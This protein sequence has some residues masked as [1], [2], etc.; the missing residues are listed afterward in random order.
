MPNIS[1]YAESVGTFID[2]WD[3]Q[4]VEPFKNL[5]PLTADAKFSAAD[6]VGGVYHVATRL[7]Y[8]GG[9]TFAAPQTQPGQLSTP[10][11]GPRAGITPDAQIQGMQVHGRSQV[12]YE[13]LARSAQN[14]NSTE[15]DRKKA[16]R[17]ASKIVM[18][19][20]LQGVLKKIE[21]QMLHGR[22]GLG[23]GDTT[24]AT[25]S[26]VVATTYESV[27]G[28][29]VDVALS[30]ATWSEA[31]WLMSEGHTFDIYANTSG[32]PAGAKLNTNPNTALAG[33]NQ[34]GLILTA[35]NP[36]TPLANGVATGRVIRLFSSDGAAGAA[37]TGDVGGWVQPIPANNTQHVMFESATPTVEFVGLGLMA[38][39][40]GTL[41]NINAATYSMYRGNLLPNVGNVRLSTLIRAFARPINAGGAGLKYR[42]VVPTELFAQFA[43]DEST[44]RR[45]ASV[46]GKAENGFDTIEMYLPQG[47]VL[48]VLGHNLQK[49]GIITGYVPD[50]VKRIGSQ[51]L[52]FVNRS[53]RR[54]E[55]F[56]LEV[57]NSPASELRLFGQFAPICETPRHMLKMTG[58]TF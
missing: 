12:T 46:T 34:N 24:V 21:T 27:A 58:V 54:K 50:E 17:A 28:F 1:G 14:V 47:S 31:I 36:A 6:M 49:D 41:F 45:Y 8:E 51:D 32:L 42:A 39:N 25:C 2:A 15:T 22:E 56:V 18:E 4:L 26:D 44:L 53:A 23:Q 35:I 33:T 52:D 9:V 37:G 3:N 55:D 29:H 19:G 48:E 16:V 30:A 13:V 38:Q 20:I 11:V 5:A 7:T 40:T 10:Y 57:A 43:N